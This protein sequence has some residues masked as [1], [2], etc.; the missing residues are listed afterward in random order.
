MY[1]AI[2]KYLS[3]KKEQGS[4]PRPLESVK[5]ARGSI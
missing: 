3:H 1:T 2:I 5:S 4:Y